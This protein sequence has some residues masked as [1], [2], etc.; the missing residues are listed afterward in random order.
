[1]VSKVS[2]LLFFTLAFVQSVLCGERLFKGDKM[3]KKNSMQDEINQN[4]PNLHWERRKVLYN[5]E[6][7]PFDEPS[8]EF[9]WHGVSYAA[10]QLAYCI[11]DS[12][13][14]L[15]SPTTLVACTA[16][17]WG[18]RRWDNMGLHLK[19]LKTPLNDHHQPCSPSVAKLWKLSVVRERRGK[20]GKRRIEPHYDEEW[21]K[22][23][24]FFHKQEDVDKWADLFDKRLCS[25]ECLKYI[26]LLLQ[27]DEREIEQALYQAVK[28]QKIRN[29]LCLFSNHKFIADILYMAPQVLPIKQL[30]ELVS[31][32]RFT[33]G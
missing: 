24:C 1:M 6:N 13:H 28:I 2:A 7:Q 32:E 8:C 12:I 27:N 25:Y 17:S 33:I 15:V 14:L 16:W 3:S 29:V 30:I 10:P 22:A 9:V 19:T 23:T 21:K 11:R 5:P 31:T 20:R 4:F 18:E 26:S